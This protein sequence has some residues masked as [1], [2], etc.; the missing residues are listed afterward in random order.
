MATSRDEFR[1]LIR[2][3]FHMELGFSHLVVYVI[4]KRLIFHKIWT[5]FYWSWWLVYAP[6]IGLFI[7]RISKGRT[8]KE[9]VLGTM[10]YG[11]L[12]CALFFGIFGNYAVYLQ[13]SGQ[14]NV[15]DFLNHHKYRGYYYAGNA[16]FT[17]PNYWIFHLLI[18]G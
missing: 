10:I 7:A 9:V 4:V 16:S 13:I 14:F 5:I 17:I 15:V 8:L 11:T 1:H 6:F 18:A 2:D 3:F 12:G